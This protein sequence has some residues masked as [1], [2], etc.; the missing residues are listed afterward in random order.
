MSSTL[1]LPLWAVHISDGVLTLPWLAGGFALAAAL[2]LFG[3][4]RIRDEEIPQVALL[5]SAFF[6]ASFIHVRIPPAS[7]H[8]LLNGLVGVI[9][10]RRAALAIPVGLLLQAALFGHGGFTTLGINSCDMVLPALLAALLF[11]GLQRVPWVRRPWFRAGLVALSSF[12]WLLSLVYGTALLVSDRN[13]GAEGAIRLALHPAVLAAVLAVSLI[14]AAFE[15]RLENAPEF[16]LGLLI[17]QMTVLTTI[18][19]TSLV[20]AWGSVQPESWRGLAQVLFVAHLPIA[21]VEGFV[22]GFAISFLVRVKP[23][24]LGW[25]PHAEREVYRSPHA[26]REAAEQPEGT[27]AAFEVAPESEPCND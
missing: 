21:L 9:L 12:L 10:G 20:L 24:M 18:A 17:G 6:V 16:P 11:A 27:C 2:A 23:E 8:L 25:L 3:A 7:V 26:P 14:A 5:T 4:W 15:R 13:S 19:L 22:L 1:I